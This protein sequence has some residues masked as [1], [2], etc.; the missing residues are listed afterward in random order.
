M[1]SVTELTLGGGLALI[2]V[3]DLRTHRIPDALSLPLIVVG[4]I[5][6]RSGSDLPWSAHLAGALAGY[7][8]LAAFGALYFHWRGRE[9]LGLGDAKLFSAAGAWLGWQSLPL[10]LLAA[11]CGG[12]LF[13]AATGPTGRHRHLAFGPWISLG[14]FVLFVFSQR[15]PPGSA[16]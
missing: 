1:L 16:S 9:G 8:T 11:C 13:A 2:S 12:L 15:V 3:I 10:V 7:L 6:S 5:W 4:L 14:F